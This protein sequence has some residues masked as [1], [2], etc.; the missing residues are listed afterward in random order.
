MKGLLITKDKAELVDY[1]GSLE[2]YYELLNCDIITITYRSVNG[3][4]ICIVCDDEGLFKESNFI[5]AVDT[6]FQPALV[7]NLLVVSVN[8]GEDLETEIFNE[9]A[10]RLIH[11]VTPIIVL[12]Y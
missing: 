4:G 10:K 12:D 8:E 9:C 1:D 5:S 2:R 3:K 6:D 11:T 7:G